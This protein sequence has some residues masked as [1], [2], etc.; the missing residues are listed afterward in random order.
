MKGG[1]NMPSHARGAHYFGKVADFLNCAVDHGKIANQAYQNIKKESG[2]GFVSKK[3]EGCGATI[4]V[5]VRPGGEW[6]QQIFPP[7]GKERK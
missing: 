6:E 3:C 1:D 7:K 4:N 5:T 2:T